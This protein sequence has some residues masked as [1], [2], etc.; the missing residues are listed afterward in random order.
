MAMLRTRTDAEAIALS[1]DEPEQFSVVFDRHFEAVHRYLHRRVGRQLADDLSAEAFAEAFRQRDRYDRAWPDARPWLFGIVANLVRRQGRNERRRLLA[2]ARNG[3][4]V[5]VDVDME[6]A[7]DRVDAAAMSRR[8]ALALASLRAEDRDVLLLL[9]W[10]DLTYEEIA[11]ALDIPEG[12]VRSR[13]HRG[14]RKLRESLEPPGRSS[15]RP[16]EKGD[17]RG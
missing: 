10:A 12:T 2:Y 3:V 8:L 7:D 6:S 17:N 14:R 16:D 5:I 13:I 15:I 11:R 9:A 1:R 4:D